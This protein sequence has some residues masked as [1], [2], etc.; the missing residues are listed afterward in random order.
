MAGHRY[1]FNNF[2]PK[3]NNNP[4][5]QCVFSAFPCGALQRFVK[6]P[7]PLTQAK[8]VFPLDEYA[9]VCGFEAFINGKHIV[10]KVKEKEQARKEYKEAISKG[11]GAYLMEEEKEQPVSFT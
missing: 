10:G 8:Y 1:L 11:H 3:T 7:S 2:Q 6:I 5:Y 4:L 9:T